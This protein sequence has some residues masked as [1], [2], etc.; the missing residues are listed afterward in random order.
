M[1]RNRVVTG[2]L[3]VFLG[4]V[5]PVSLCLA[6]DRSHA[7]IGA[8]LFSAIV[9]FGAFVTLGAIVLFVY[10]KFIFKQSLATS[11]ITSFFGLDVLFSVIVSV[12]L[13][14]F[15]V[16]AIPSDIG[17]LPHQAAFFAVVVSCIILPPVLAVCV[18]HNRIL[19]QQG[20]RAKIRSAYLVIAFFFV[21]YGLC[22][23]GAWLLEPPQCG[24]ICTDIKRTFPV[25]EVQVEYKSTPRGDL[26][27][28]LSVE[29]IDPAADN[30]AA[31]ATKILN[32]FGMTPSTALKELD[33]V[34]TIVL[35]FSGAAHDASH[36]WQ[37]DLSKTDA[38]DTKK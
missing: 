23:F 2:V 16:M 33:G 22:L 21:I 14:S 28:Y 32:H 19:K 10:A 38:S 1:M 9:V 17:Q 26:Y 36:L 35:N 13:F 3:S 4:L 24:A 18:I 30:D 15:F 5:F 6:G 25:K 34:E 7:S 12:V 27:M 8:V 20:T 37:K 11:Q 29:P 31:L